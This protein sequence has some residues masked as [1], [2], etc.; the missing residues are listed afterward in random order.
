MSAI[1]KPKK[2]HTPNCR[3]FV[4]GG[5]RSHYCSN[6]R[7]KHW[8]AK[9]PLHYYFNK[10]KQRA[11]ERGKEFELT[12]EQYI[13]FAKST[14]YAKLKGKT[15]TSLSIDRI[16]NDGPYAWWNIQAITLR[17]NSRKEHV[18]FWQQQHNI[19]YKPTEEE[20]KEAEMAV[21]NQ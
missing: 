2:C 14:N 3:K 11:K 5:A 6:C 7:T 18:P 12:R 1:K 16:K 20:I 4:T 9:Y 10:L 19:T 13:Y 21:K 15:S 17:Q 8:R